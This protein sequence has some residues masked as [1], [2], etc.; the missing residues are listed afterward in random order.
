MDQSVM[1]KMILPEE[2]KALLEKSKNKIVV[3]ESRTH[4]LELAM[5]SQDEKDFI[6]IAYEV[7][8]KG[9]VVEATVAKCKNGC[10]VNYMD[11]YMRRRDP[12]SMVV[13]DEKDTDKPRYEEVFEADFEPIRKE[14][15]EWLEEQD[16]IVMPFMA[17]GN[18]FGYQALLVGPLNAGFFAGGLADLQTFI[19]KGELPDNFTPK[20][21]IYLAPP[22]RHTHFDGK[23]IVVHNRLDDMHELFSYNLYPG[24]SAKKGI[25]GV[26]LNIGEGEGWVT[27][28][29]ST[30]KVVTPYENII[31]I[32]H[33]GASGGGKSE[34]L[35]QPH[36]QPDGRMVLATNSITKEKTYMELVDESTLLPVT[37]DMAL[38]HPA[39]QNDS[40]KLVV[41]DAE[42]GWFLR[43]NH[44][45]KY[46]TDPHY[47]RLTIHPKEP[48]IFLN[49]DGVPGAT[50]LIWEHTMD[51]NGKPCPNPRVIMPRSFIPGIVDEPV[52]VDVRSFG[53]RTPLCTKE[54]PTYGMMGMVQ[55]LPPA[56][57][58]LWRLVAPRGHDNPSIVSGDAMGSEGVGSYWPFATGKKVD[59]ANL[60]LEQ[61][62]NTSAT[63]Y[64]LIPNQNIGAYK[65]GFMSEW[66]TREYISRRGSAK[67]RR[68]NMVPS[69]CGLLGYALETMKIDGH[70][71]PKGLLQPQLQPEVGTE[72]YDA[73]AKILDDFFKKELPQFLEPGLNPLGREIIEACL[74]NCSLEEYE[75]FIPIQW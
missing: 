69:R 22:F 12:D 14:T 32:M 10:S 36:K 30:V 50:C 61:I 66:M 64:I 4:L 11:M 58:W 71:M 25:Y 43:I 28:H 26:L 48:L 9:R 65:V 55:V 62:L 60:L 13:A 70:Y 47:E 51:E 57:A 23:Q 39:L 17:G 27:A 49:I 59:Q 29:A 68:E 56:L 67:F 2:L 42:N 3:P 34:M 16:L 41:Q 74:N 31:V 46:G 54:N 44:I 24:P 37:D 75:K 45:D 15:F 52:E 38:C 8:G 40:K 6:E 18:S 33:E 63:R 73:G 19:P 1:D 35:E 72:G 7:P 20:A 5:G 53:V 21:V